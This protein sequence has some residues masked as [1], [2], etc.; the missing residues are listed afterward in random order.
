MTPT[1]DHGNVIS[2]VRKALAH[3][4]DPRYLESLPYFE[5]LT[6]DEEGMLSRGQALC[7]LLR[8]SIEAVAPRGEGTKS[9]LDSRAHEILFRYAIGKQTIIGISMQLGISQRQAYRELQRAADAV[10]WQ[11][12]LLSRDTLPSGDSG[13]SSYGSEGEIPDELER[14][15][16]SDNQTVDLGM[17]LQDVGSSIRELAERRQVGI[18]VKCETSQAQV[19]ANRVMLRQALLNLSSHLVGHASG[20]AD[21]GFHLTRSDTH[22]QISLGPF[23]HSG[24]EQA[25]PN[26]PFAVAIHLL[27]LLDLEW[28]FYPMDG[29][30]SSI[31]IELPLIKRRTV[32]IIDDNKDLIALFRRFLRQ[33]PYTV[34]GAN[35][36]NA[37]AEFDRL[38][39]DVVILDVMM[40]DQD[41]WEI[42][43]VLRAREQ[44]SLPKIIVCTIIN[45]PDL[46]SVLGANGF[47]NKP[48]RRD[49]LVGMVRSVLT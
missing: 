2:T 35:S 39:P 46:A 27:D 5:N 26:E 42:L 48:V 47:L 8:L 28:C 24:D 31:R 11:L 6:V 36:N 16:A 21:I 40:P 38:Q 29:G 7:S 49:Q 37:L 1:N 33:E 18:N 34:I 25:I 41:G 30:M 32:L 22:A 23:T 13:P 44:C 4:N 19:S 20:Q 43:R 45:D 17:L 12:G 3:L 14:L 10:A 9:M 15:M